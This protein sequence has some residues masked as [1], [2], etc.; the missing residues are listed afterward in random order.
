MAANNEIGTIQPVAQIGA[1]A[2]RHRILFHTDAVQAYTNMDIDVNAMQIDM[3]STSAHK[4]NGP[5]GIGFLYIREGCVKTPFIHGGRTGAW[6]ALRH[7]KYGRDYRFC[8][9]GADCHGK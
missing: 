8:K 3:L 1:F 6:D 5:K 7:G 4:L 2:R 9:G